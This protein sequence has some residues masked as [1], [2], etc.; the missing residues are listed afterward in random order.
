MTKFWNSLPHLLQA[1]IVLFA[2]TVLSSIAKAIEA[3]N[4]CWSY[5]CWRGYLAG[6]LHAGVVAVAALYLRSSLYQP[7]PNNVTIGWRPKQ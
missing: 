4:A 3:P 7:P 6:G 1:V 2:A 5:T